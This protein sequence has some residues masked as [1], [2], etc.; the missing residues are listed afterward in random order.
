M[1]HRHKMRNSV[2][3]M[4]PIDLP[5]AGLTPSFNLCKIPYLGSTIKRRYAYIKH[6]S[7]LHHSA[8]CCLNCSQEGKLK[9]KKW[10]L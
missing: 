10:G 8:P 1:T 3:K 7:D 6:S 2:G 4:S 5:D 9:E